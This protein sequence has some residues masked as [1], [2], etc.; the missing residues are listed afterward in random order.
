MEDQANFINWDLTKGGLAAC[1]E[2]LPGRS[3]GAIYEPKVIDVVVCK[4][5]R[6]LAAAGW[7]GA[8]HGRWGEGYE[9]VETAD[10]DA[11]FMH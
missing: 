7:A 10:A 3:A 5:R 1:L 9:L 2:K 6:K 4:L 11:A 8:I